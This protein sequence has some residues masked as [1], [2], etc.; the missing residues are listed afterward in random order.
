MSRNGKPKL[1]EGVELALRI[2]LEKVQQYGPPY[3][4]VKGVV[5]SINRNKRCDDCY[6]GEVDGPGWSSEQWGEYRD[7]EIY[8]Q[9]V[10]T[11]TPRRL[12]GWE[13]QFERRSFIRL[14]EAE[15][16]TR[17]LR[18]IERSLEKQKQSYGYPHTFGQFC[19]RVAI[20]IGATRFL[21]QHEEPSP[22]GYVYDVTDLAHGIGRI[23]QMVEEW[24]KEGE[25]AEV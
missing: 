7:L 4:H 8:S 11:D 14:H 21:F 24:V 2:F 3:V 5:R 16:M 23:D 12:Y 20:A 10:D 6:L 13:V 25:T 9:G 22:D 19:G 18:R 15:E 17:T 1:P